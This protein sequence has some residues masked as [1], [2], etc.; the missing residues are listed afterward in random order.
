MINKS[1]TKLDTLLER[2]I[3]RVL[4]EVN[5]TVYVNDFLSKVKPNSKT[6]YNLDKQSIDAFKKLYTY[7]VKYKD[8]EVGFIGV[9]RAN[10]ILNSRETDYLKKYK[11][12]ESISQHIKHGVR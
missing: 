4:K 9:R 6:Y 1:K 3:K 10:E 12:M 11:A 8:R 7:L 5:E 2:M